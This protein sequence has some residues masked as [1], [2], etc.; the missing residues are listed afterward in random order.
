[1]RCWGADLSGQLGDGD[2]TAKTTPVAPAW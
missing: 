1:V 2:T